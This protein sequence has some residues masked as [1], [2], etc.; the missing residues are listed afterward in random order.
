MLYM[1][2]ITA[3]NWLYH[4]VPQP[5]K[6]TTLYPLNAIKEVYPDIYDQQLQKYHGRGRILQQKIPPLDNCLWNDVLFMVALDPRELYRTRKDAGFADIS[7][8][9][10]YKN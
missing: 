10:Y 6:G 4:H 7:P 9:Y 1:V 3:M 5:I 2:Y 8:Q